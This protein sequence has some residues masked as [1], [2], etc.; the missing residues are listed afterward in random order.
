MIPEPDCTSESSEE[1]ISDVITRAKTNNPKIPAEPYS[2]L[3]TILRDQIGD[4]K[5]TQANLR[6]VA[7][8]LLGNMATEKPGPEASN[9]N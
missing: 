9:E 6:K 5:L 2:S 4:R 8:Q 1:W 3:E 7:A